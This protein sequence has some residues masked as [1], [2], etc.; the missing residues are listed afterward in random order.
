MGH[1]EIHIAHQGNNCQSGD[2]FT[3]KGREDSTTLV[4]H[5]YQSGLR[6][7]NENG[8]RT[9]VIDALLSPRCFH[10]KARS[11][12]QFHSHNPQILLSVPTP[13]FSLGVTKP[14]MSADNTRDH[15][16]RIK[17]RFHNIYN[18]LQLEFARHKKI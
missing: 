5:C 13:L 1:G 15:F 16:W 8:G 6:S 4:K 12:W 3:G 2:R 18:F 17:A 10:T 7:V 11:L 14:F 9:A